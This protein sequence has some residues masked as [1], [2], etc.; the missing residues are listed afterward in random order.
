MQIRPNRLK[1]HAPHMY[2]KATGLLGK[3]YTLCSRQGILVMAGWSRRFSG[4]WRF[5][6]ASF[7][8]R[9]TPLTTKDFSFSPLF[10]FSFPRHQFQRTPHQVISQYTRPSRSP[11]LLQTSLKCVFNPLVNYRSSPH[12][13]RS[14]RQ[15][16]SPNEKKKRS[17][18]TS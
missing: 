13:R 7:S 14:T 15:K 10:S 17:F 12:H 1:T 3:R 11:P 16:Q 18:A 4:W 6:L 8:I 9:R 5:V 2:F